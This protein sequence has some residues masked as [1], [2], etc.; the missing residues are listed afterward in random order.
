M[1]RYSLLMVGG[2]VCLHHVAV[3]I[4]GMTN[5]RPTENRQELSEAVRILWLP[6]STNRWQNITMG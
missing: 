3:D 5:K 2:G 6:S 4:C 1:L